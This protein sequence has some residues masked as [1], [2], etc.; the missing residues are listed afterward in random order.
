MTIVGYGRVSTEDQKLQL[1]V[2]ALKAA[3]C[4]KLF[5]EKASGTNRDRP[6]LER[7]LHYLKAGDTLKVWK[8]DRLARSL[9]HL[10][11]I[12]EDLK[13]RG[14]AFEVVSDKLAFNIA[15]PIGKLIF[16]LLG[17][18]GEFERALI[19]ERTIAGMAA[20]KAEGRIA[21]RKHK[22]T[23]SDVARARKMA[24]KKT[25]RQVAEKFKVSESTLRT[26][27]NPQR[28]AAA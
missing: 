28:E 4:T 2:S 7:C 16:Q 18:F 17:S 27:L 14:I 24:V 20:A 1:Q 12:V 13:A 11:E 10:I 8:L 3:G 23:E 22:L 26:Y 21:G 9:L 19:S 25:R 5:L 6:Q 15:T